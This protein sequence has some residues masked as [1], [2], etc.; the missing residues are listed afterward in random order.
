VPPMPPT[1]PIP[2]YPSVSTPSTSGPQPEQAG[3]GE[4]ETDGPNLEA[5][6]E[7]ILR[8]IAEGR[9]TPEE[10]DMLLEGLND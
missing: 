10:G 2:P 6:R 9:V 1:P 3:E 4:S 5:E 8:M 7:A